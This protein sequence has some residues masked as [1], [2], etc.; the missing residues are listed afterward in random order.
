MPKKLKKNFEM[1][2][3]INRALI[4]MKKR[5]HTKNMK[6]SNLIFF[7]NSNRNWLKSK[8][9]G[10]YQKLIID[11][12]IEIETD[13][14]SRKLQKTNCFDDRVMIFIWPTRQEISD[15]KLGALENNSVKG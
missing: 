5:W 2:K 14:W 6:L 1:S 3:L 11:F 9:T 8:I 13:F 15:K 7:V 12:E 10:C 4:K